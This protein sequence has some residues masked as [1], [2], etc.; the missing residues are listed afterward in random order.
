MLDFDKLKSDW[1]S[2]IGEGSF[3]GLVVYKPLMH[4]LPTSECF[5]SFDDDHAWIPYTGSEVV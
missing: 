1:A 4:R 5:T 2:V 3:D